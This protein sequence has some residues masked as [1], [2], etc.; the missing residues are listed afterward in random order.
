MLLFL[1]VLF[2]FNVKDNNK[3]FH[4]YIIL[5]FNSYNI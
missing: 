5:D 3:F 1:E 2:S 4:V